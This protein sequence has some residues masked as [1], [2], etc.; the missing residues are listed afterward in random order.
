MLHTI[1]NIYDVVREDI[2]VENKTE[3]Y[4]FSTNPYDYL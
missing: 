3:N 4:T 2:F 1:V